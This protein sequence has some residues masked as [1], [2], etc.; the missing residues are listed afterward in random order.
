MILLKMRKIGRVNRIS[1]SKWKKGVRK[2]LEK[3]ICSW[4]KYTMKMC[5]KCET[6]ALGD[7]ILLCPDCGE[8]F[9]N[10]QTTKVNLDASEL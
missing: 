3:I 10:Y 4:G 8:P 7:D 2:T 1:L 5:L 9:L 6:I